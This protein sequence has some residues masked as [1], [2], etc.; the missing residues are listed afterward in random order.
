MKCKR[1]QH[2]DYT[3]AEGGVG[4]CQAWIIKHQTPFVK[5]DYFGTNINAYSSS[6]EYESQ[7]PCTEYTDVKPKLR[8]RRKTL[9]EM[10]MDDYTNQPESM[11]QTHNHYPL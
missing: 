7:C 4:Q 1:C 5:T 10:T 8:P 11:K 2:D 9:F 3:H 6:I